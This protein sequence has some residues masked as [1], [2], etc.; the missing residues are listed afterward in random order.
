MR[1]GFSLIVLAAGLSL[2]DVSLA[3]AAAAET[4]TNS[5]ACRMPRDFGSASQLLLQQEELLANLATANL[6]IDTLTRALDTA[7]LAQNAELIAIYEGALGNAQAKVR[8]FGSAEQNLRQS[9]DGARNLRLC[10][11]AA[12]SAINLGNVYI[13]RAR[14]SEMGSLFPEAND[15]YGR[16]TTIYDQA[17]TDATRAGDR[18]LADLAVINR[19]RVTVRSGISDAFIDG[20]SRIVESANLQ[21]ASRTASR[22][23]VT[24]GHIITQAL[25]FSGSQ[26]ARDLALR[27]FD[28][29]ASRA[30]AASDLRGESLALGFLGEFYERQGDFA[31]AETVTSQALFNAQRIQAADLLYRWNWQIG[32]LRAV[33][34]D[35]DGAEAA[36]RRA[37][38]DVESIRG[39][40]PVDYVNGSS[41]FLETTGELYRQFANVLLRNAGRY[42]QTARQLRVDAQSTLELMKISELYNYFYDLC[43]DPTRVRNIADVD[44]RT[45]VLYPVLLPDRLEV[46]V[47]FPQG[48][49][50]PEAFVVNVDQGTVIDAA[51]R[52]RTLL[53]DG[54]PQYVAPAS[55]LYGW[56]FGDALQATLQRNNIETLVWIPDGALRGIP[57]AALTPDGTD[58]VIDHY[59]VATAPGLS[60]VDPR[61][62]GAAAGSATL[63]AGV[64]IEV[65]GFG[66]PALPNVPTWINE[67]NSVRPGR[68]FL[69]ADFEVDTLQ[70][71]LSTVPYGVVHI[72]AHAKFDHDQSY[73][74][75]SNGPLTMDRLENAVKQSGQGGG[76]LELIVLE[77]CETAAG[78]DRAALGLG[79]IAIKAGARS[80]VATL[81]PIYENPT[82]RLVVE[83][84]RGI[85]ET[86]GLSKAQALRAAQR[87]LK[88]DPNFSHPYYWSPYLLIGNWL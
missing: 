84:Y 56:I 88:S 29:A 74:L 27:A 64:S 65:P 31:S 73:I 57:L 51:R 22:N 53:Q 75:T 80:A 7:R 81:W 54:D 82:S 63:L 23:L 3:W 55:E 85:S 48:A 67:I 15:F 12:I 5:D 87:A 59:A 79:G 8:A 14:A 46:L 21:P 18:E 1:W 37:V 45:A 35:F 36:L 33:N 9:I 78:D 10:R 24:I 71:E 2:G 69:N 16:A 25:A 86:R 4:P 76:I 38:R 26:R 41:S 28:V 44:V 83:F 61:P 6:A 19:A 72:A 50:D 52:L 32:R 62:I 11:V 20:L 66:L 47:F 13:A 77:G 17:E 40:I 58:F 39:D 43:F 49:Q 68:V 42:P 60:L 70:Q 34:G 30:R